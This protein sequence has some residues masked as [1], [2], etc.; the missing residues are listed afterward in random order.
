MYFSLFNIGGS[1]T[2][3]NFYIEL[4]LIETNKMSSRSLFAIYN[5]APGKGIDLLW[6]HIKNY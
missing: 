2:F 6:L 1:K 3:S 4:C 5:D